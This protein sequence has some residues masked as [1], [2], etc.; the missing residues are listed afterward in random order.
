MN[1]ISLDTVEKLQI[2][3]EGLQATLT[4]RNARIAQ[5]EAK[6]A[7][8]VDLG[9]ELEKKLEKAYKTGWQ[10]CAR[11]FLQAAEEMKKLGSNVYY[12]QEK[13]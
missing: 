2:H 8:P 5:L 9:P 7:L 11:Q 4:K 3:I 12:E 1:Q 13:F 10:K 6:L